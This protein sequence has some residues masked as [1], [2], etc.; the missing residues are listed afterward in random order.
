MN[1]LY[2]RLTQGNEKSIHILFQTTN[3]FKEVQYINC[4]ILHS[5]LQSSIR[6]ITKGNNK[7]INTMKPIHLFDI[8]I[9][10]ALID[11]KIEGYES[12]G[13]EIHEHPSFFQ[14]PYTDRESQVFAE[15]ATLISTVP[16][17]H[18]SLLQPVPSRSASLEDSFNSKRFGISFSASISPSWPVSAQPA[19][20]AYP[21]HQ[22]SN[23]YSSPS[24]AS[25]YPA[26]SIRDCSQCWCQ[27]KS[28]SYRGSF[29]SIE[30]NCNR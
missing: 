28:L 14:T 8:L 6:V 11:V 16:G 19:T 30:G 3:D 23:V 27:C 12:S 9:I 2:Q 22:P 24:F 15:P 1:T 25:S 18:T 13:Y 4:I 21:F 29:G 7:L 20:R 10:F 26:K 5:L 17:E